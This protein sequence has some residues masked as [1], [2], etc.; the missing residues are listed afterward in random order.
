MTAPSF[1]VFTPL[2]NSS[3]IISRVWESLGSQSYRDFEWIVVDDGSADDSASVVRG[4]KDQAWF[5]VTLIEQPNQG[6]HVAWNRAVKLARGELFVPLDHDDRCVGSALERFAHHW[7]SIPEQ[8]RD[9]YSGINVLCLNPATNQ[10]VGDRF[11]ESPLDT[12][13]LELEYVYRVRGEKW[14]CIRTDALRSHPFLE[15]TTGWLPES[16]IWYQLA[17]KWKV[18]C[19]NEPLR[20]YFRDQ[21]THQSSG[22][23]L[24]KLGKVASRYIYNIWHFNTNLDYIKRDKKALLFVASNIWRLGHHLHKSISETLSSVKH[25]RILCLMCLPV[26]LS[27][28]RIDRWLGNVAARD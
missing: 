6:K 16:Y 22:R 26:G 9:A 14:G 19:V 25:N 4:Y 3:R 27:V 23:H 10:I 21:A 20:L 7:L 17:R 2:F 18:R 1:T 13:N 11:P 15:S 5:P 24:G 28:A 8:D 12:N